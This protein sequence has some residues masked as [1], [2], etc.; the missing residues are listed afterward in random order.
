M[1]EPIRTAIA[2]YG[3]SGQVF[4]GPLLKAHEGFCIH[5]ILERTGSISSNKHPGAVLVRSFEVLCED[6]LIELIVVNT[7]DHLHYSMA[8]SA[9]EAGKHV[10]VEKPFTLRYSEAEELIGLARKRELLL[11]V[12]QNRRWD[13]DFLTVQKIIQEN[14]LGKISR[15]E[16]HFD[17]YRPEVNHATWKES[18]VAETG[19]LYNLGSH[20]IDQALVLFGKPQAVYADI[21]AMRE[22]A[23]TDDSFDLLLRYDDIKVRLTADYMIKEPVVKYEVHGQDGSFVKQGQDP[24]EDAM[25]SG[26][27]PGI[28]EWGIEPESYAGI[29]NFRKEGKDYRIRQVSEKGNYLAFYDGI[30]HTL[31]AGGKNP[32]EPEDAALVIQ[33]IEAAYRS[34]RL[35]REVEIE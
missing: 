22:G 19:T 32:V 9:L 6:P 11:S 26:K 1:P 4:H 30:Y 12:F 2:S 35:R 3:M 31:R 34:N 18:G 5:A 20:L 23:K 17:R 13:S 10:V 16:A 7:P 24:Q 21:R 33:I 29:L 8:K 27:A 14:K 15:F 28:S 25:K